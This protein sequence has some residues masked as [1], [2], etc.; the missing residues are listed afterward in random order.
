MHKALIITPTGCSM[1]YD[2]EYDKE[3]HWRF[4]KPNRSYEVCVIGFKEDYVPEMYSYDYFFHYP[5]RH[6][7]KALPELCDF[8]AE[9]GIRWW[10]Y[11]YIGYWD[12]DYCTDIQSV[13][14]ALQ[15]ARQFDMRLFQQ[16][17]TS[18]T[19]Y[20][21]LEQNKE[22][23]F[24]ETNF[25]EMGVPFYRADVFRKVLTLLTDYVYNESEWGIDKIM[26]DYLRQTA[27]VIH[28]S[29]IKHMRRESWYDKAN[30]FAEMDYLMR[31]W[32]PKYMKER[33]NIDYKYTDA[34][35]I[36]RA[37]INQNEQG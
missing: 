15:L 18:W 14:K 13:E 21:C 1:F 7:W 28:A 17:L 37:Y 26:C 9:K 3:N 10:D 23:M 19:V 24:A 20:P 25:T 6:K 36:L 2:D 32:F 12:D 29:S 31:D 22:W 34:Q 5:V 8:L 27:H 4:Q 33:F 35:V 30:A 16:S 11:D